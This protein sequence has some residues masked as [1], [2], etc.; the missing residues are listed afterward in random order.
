MFASEHEVICAVRA[1]SEAEYSEFLSRLKISFASD[2]SLPNNHK[3]IMIFVA[4]NQ[5]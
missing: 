2:D 5:S 1:K 4:G 3:N